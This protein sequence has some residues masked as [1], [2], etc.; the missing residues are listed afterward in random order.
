LP[1]AL[2]QAGAYL[3]ETGCTLATYQQLYRSQRRTLLARRVG[4]IPDHPEPV[5]TTWQLAFERLQ[6]DQPPAADLL[7]LC[8]CLSPDAIPEEL[9]TEGAAHLGER[10][11]PVA[12]DPLLLNAAIESLRAYSLLGRSRSTQTLS[13]HPLV[14]AVL[15]DTM[16]EPTRTLWAERAVR[17]VNA[18]FPSVEFASW[19]QCERLLPQA[20]ACA[21][22]IEHSQLTFPQAARLLND[23]AYY[24]K[25]QSRY[26]EAE[27]LYK[28]A[29]AIREQQLGLEHPDTALSLN[30]LAELYRG[31]STSRPS[32]C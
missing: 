6:A 28:R 25:V 21:Q 16:D 13:L 14:Q 15:L 11:T 17:V 8:A 32:C 2:D 27:P 24:L 29:L 30:N 10:L 31:A 5:A 20:L 19:P 4:R 9:L 22:H 1:L 12:A 26:P 7:R 23:T 3:E 18:A